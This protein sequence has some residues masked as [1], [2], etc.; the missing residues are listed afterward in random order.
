MLIRVLVSGGAGYI[1]TV[2]CNY[3]ND[4]KINFAIID[5]FSTSSPKYLNKKFILYKGNINNLLVLKKIYKEFRPTHIVHLAASIDVNE[6][7]INKKKY[8]KNN[9][10]NSKK[11]IDFFIKNNVKNFLFSSTAAVYNSN[12]DV[13]S[14]K[15]KQRPANYY[16]FT[17]LLIE[18]FLLKKK[19]SNKLEVK[20]LRFFNIVG[21]DKRLRS[22]NI[23]KKSKH[24]FNSLSKSFFLK[25]VFKI[26]GNNYNTKDGT[27]VRDFIDVN[28]LVK[29]IIFFIKAKNKNTIFN[30]G[31][32]RGFSVL[33][34]LKFFKKVLKID[35]N[36]RYYKK[37][38]GDAPRLVCKNLLLRKIYKAR[39]LGIKTSIRNHY[40][41]YKK[42]YNFFV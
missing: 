20:I 30:I 10:L 13:K 8:Y 16:G 40:L 5:N 15:Y 23:S 41:F 3:L 26:N 17:K 37:R 22:G 11:F 21:S 4:Y 25:K 9:V 12:K 32:N 14:E 2:L 38:T 6:S 24:L 36:Y 42:N 18:N 29:V 31:T 39:F 28:D 35:I 19:L 1:G 33:E 34:I 7:E 27:C